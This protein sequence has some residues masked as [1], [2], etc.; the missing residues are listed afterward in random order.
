[1]K[2]KNGAIGNYN[3][4]HEWDKYGQWAD[5]VEVMKA[6]GGYGGTH[7]GNWNIW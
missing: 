1:M 6:M 2:A 5:F 7:E 4:S 3:E